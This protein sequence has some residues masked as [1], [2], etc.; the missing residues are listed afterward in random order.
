MEVG[1]RL[2][3]SL[4]MGSKTG[5][6]RGVGSTEMLCLSWAQVWG[7]GTEPNQASTLQVAVVT[8][9]F[10]SE[11]GWISLSAQIICP[12]CHHSVHSGKQTAQ[13]HCLPLSAIGGSLLRGS[14]LNHNPVSDN[15]MF[16]L[17]RGAGGT[18]P[19]DR[20]AHLHLSLT[21]LPSASPS[22]YLFP[23]QTISSSMNGSDPLSGSL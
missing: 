3:H 20:A 13:P 16:W 19:G 22:A 10:P 1:S 4:L 5:L 9:F 17:E 23:L 21:G 15:T 7:D 8:L 6:A 12:G 14:V 11:G 18:G 2:K